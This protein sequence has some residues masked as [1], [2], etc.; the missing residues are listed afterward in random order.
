MTEYRRQPSVLLRV[1]LTT[2]LLGLL[3]FIFSN[4]LQTG[5]QSSA[6]SGGITE[7]LQKLAKQIAP[8]SFIATATGEDYDRLHAFV[9]MTA[10]FLEFCALGAVM[11]WCF[12]SYTLK[13]RHAPIALIC[14]FITAFLDEFLQTLTAGRGAEIKDIL[15]DC[16]GGT[17]GAVFALMAL[18]ILGIVLKKG[19]NYGK[20]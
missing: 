18:V 10:H 15:V 14:T 20:S 9:R 13:K 6:Q 3:G 16:L 12:Y 7:L 4:S 1:I 5:E 17:V 2:L 11:V 19:G 8:N